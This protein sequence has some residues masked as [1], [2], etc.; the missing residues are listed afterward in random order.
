MMRQCPD[1]GS[2]DVSAGTLLALAINDCSIAVRRLLLS[3]EREVKV[4][5]LLTAIAA[6]RTLAPIRQLQAGSGRPQLCV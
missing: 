4:R 6:E 3:I 1:Q 5:L 2:A